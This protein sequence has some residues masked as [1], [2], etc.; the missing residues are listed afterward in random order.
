M[1]MDLKPAVN[2]INILRL[3]F[4]YESLFGSF[5]YL[6]IAGEKLLKI[7]L[8]KKL[9]RKMLM[10]LTPGGNQFIGI[11]KRRQSIKRSSK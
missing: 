11:T 9:A 5:F 3:N 2:F 1:L 7:P 6:H 4:M 10:K 8:Y